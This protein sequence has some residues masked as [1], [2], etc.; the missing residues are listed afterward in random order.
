MKF[1]NI[2]DLEILIEVVFEMLFE[3]IFFECMVMCC[4]VEVF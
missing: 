2:E 3:F 4:G 1:E